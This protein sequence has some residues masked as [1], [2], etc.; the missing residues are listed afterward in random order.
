[1]LYDRTLSAEEVPQGLIADLADLTVV[2]HGIDVDGN[3]QYSLD[4]RIGESPLAQALGMQGVRAEATY[5]AN[6]G[7][8]LG[9]TLR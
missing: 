1:M 9:A 8:A 2:Q 7:A 5:P 4:T 3:P 6:C